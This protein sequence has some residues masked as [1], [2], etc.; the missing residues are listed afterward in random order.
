M[1]DSGFISLLMMRA[2]HECNHDRGRWEGR[3]SPDPAGRLGQD[4]ESRPPGPGI[5]GS[6]GGRVP[7]AEPA[8]RPCRRSGPSPQSDC[9][10]RCRRRRTHPCRDRWR[11]VVVKN[12]RPPLASGCHG[13]ALPGRLP[14]MTP[15]RPERPTAAPMACRRRAVAVCTPRTFPS[16]ASTGHRCR[17]DGQ[18]DPMTE[19]CGT[20]PGWL[21]TLAR[22]RGMDCTDF[23]QHR[24]CGRERHA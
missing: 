3:E 17:G 12:S 10:F 8:A 6:R 1:I 21:R 20:V 14:G 15:L 13:R 22:R 24:G 19:F 5:S 4:E 23:V 2:V 16:P 11:T 9:S 18:G 7:C